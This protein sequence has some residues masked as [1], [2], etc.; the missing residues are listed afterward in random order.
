M[1]DWHSPI[2]LAERYAG[3]RVVALVRRLPPDGADSPLWE[4]FRKFADTL[5]NLRAQLAR[6][7]PLPTMDK[8]RTG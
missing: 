6:P 3:L 2:R 1:S 8:R 4:E 5:A 7:A